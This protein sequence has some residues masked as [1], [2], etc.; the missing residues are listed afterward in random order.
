[1]TDRAEDNRVG[2][3]VV[4]VCTEKIV[5]LGHR[6]VYERRPACVVEMDELGT[7]V[8]PEPSVDELGSV[9]VRRN[10]PSDLRLGQMCTMSTTL[11][12]HT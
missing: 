7:P 12:R 1:M 9:W 4:P 3:P 10:K 8:V 11:R 6:H 2:M 5:S